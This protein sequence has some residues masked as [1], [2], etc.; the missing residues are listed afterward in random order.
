MAR[1]AFSWLSGVTP[2]QQSLRTATLVS[3]EN[4]LTRRALE[5]T[6]ISVHTPTRFDL[7]VPAASYV[8]AQRYAAERGFV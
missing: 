6:Q 4:A 8:L 3:G 7:A 1:S 5:M 2:A